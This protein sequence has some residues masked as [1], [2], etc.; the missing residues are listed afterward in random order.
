VL[1][2]ALI[3]G[4]VAS[5]I[6]VV[7]GLFLAHGLYA[8]VSS[9]GSGLP[10]ADLVLQPSTV[11]IGMVLGT[12]ITVAASALPARKASR[13]SPVEA[14]REAGDAAQPLGRIRIIAGVAVTILGALLIALGLFAGTGAAFQLLGLGALLLYLGV[15]SLAPLTVV[16]IA[17]TLGA[18]IA[19]LRRVPGKLARTNAIR[20]PRRGPPAA[21]A[22]RLSA[23]PSA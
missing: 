4:V 21:L 9:L 13:V 18:P 14:I 19:A 16:P 8:A 10:K 20:A 3:T 11:I 15:S 17:G 7:A 5:A 22:P 23:T 12:A 6:G 1:A 2:E